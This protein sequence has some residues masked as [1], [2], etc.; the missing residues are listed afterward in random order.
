MNTN[1]DKPLDPTQPALLVRYGSTQQSWKPLERDVLLIGRSIR[2][3]LRL[4]SPEVAPIHCVLIR[5]ADG[6][7]VRDC[8]S[9]NGTRVNG[10]AVQEAPLHDG[11]VLQIG[12]FSFEAKLPCPRQDPIGP[13]GTRTAAGSDNGRLTKSRR[14][15]ARLALRLRARLRQLSVLRNE[16]LTEPGLLKREAE[17]NRQMAQLN[18]RVRAC[19]QRDRQIKQTED[20]LAVD[21]ETLDQEFAAFHARMERAEADLN[22]READLDAEL[23]TRWQQCDERCRQLEHANTQRLDEKAKAS[24]EALLQQ[25]RVLQ[26]RRK[27]QDCFARHLAQSSKKLIQQHLEAA[28]KLA[29]LVALREEN[30]RL[31]SL[32][33][34]NASDPQSGS[35]GNSWADG[36][37]SGL[38]AEL[39]AW[40]D[41]APKPNTHYPRKA[42]AVAPLEL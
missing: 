12:T 25:E 2:C 24:E 42:D 17:L 20:E 4:D 32:V 35:D 30:D 33:M 11:D 13:V 39:A 38:S 18:E 10:R 15:F 28:D 26:L 21:R 22:R 1:H 6:W 29:E 9:Q 8:G 16:P 19:D 23:R 5:R 7:Q 27:E 31:R 40:R 14:R 36:A 37:S 3:D 41:K 34:A